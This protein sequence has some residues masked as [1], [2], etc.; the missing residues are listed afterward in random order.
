MS[1]NKFIVNVGSSSGKDKISELHIALEPKRSR[2]GPEVREALR[3][4]RNQQAIDR[5]VDQELCMQLNTRRI[6]IRPRESAELCETV[7]HPSQ[8]DGKKHRNYTSHMDTVPLFGRIIA[9]EMVIP[10]SGPIQVRLEVARHVVQDPGI[11]IWAL[12][13]SCD[14]LL[15]KTLGISLIS[16]LSPEN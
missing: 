3:R 16:Q 15:C 4:D 2:K 5:T 11:D 1:K 14:E 6:V 13:S 12:T 9:E 7:E 8:I 10:E